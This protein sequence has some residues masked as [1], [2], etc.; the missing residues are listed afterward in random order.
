MGPAYITSMNIPF[1]KS[2]Q[3]E[4]GHCQNPKWANSGTK[5]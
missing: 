2:S 1:A 5:G 3:P 4:S